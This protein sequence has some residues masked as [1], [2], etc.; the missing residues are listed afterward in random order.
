[1]GLTTRALLRASHIKPWSQSTDSERLDP[2]NGILL[3]AHID[4]LFIE[5]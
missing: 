3:A 1:L 5:V 2:A 4:A